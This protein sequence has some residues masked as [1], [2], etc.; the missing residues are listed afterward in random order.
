M[1]LNLGTTEAPEPKETGVYLREFLMDPLVLDIPSFW[2]WFLVNIIIV[3]RR[4]IASARAYKKIWLREGSPLLF[5]SQ[6][7]VGS[8]TQHLQGKFLVILGM[9]YGKPSIRQA[10][11]ELKNAG[12]E[13][14]Y[15]LPLYPQFADSSTRTALLK[16]RDELSSLNWSPQIAKCLPHFF[17]FS[18][19]SK[20]FAE[21][22]DDLN[23]EFCAD[24]IL[25]SYHG[26]PQRHLSQRRDLRNV[27]RF[28]GQC[29]GEWSSRNAL[30]YRAQCF[31]T[32]R[33]IVQLLD[34]DPNRS[35]TAFQSR[36][37]R[38]KWI[39]PSI[40][41]E[42]SRL[43]RA[44]VKRL[45]VSCPSFVTDC[46]ETLEE[47]GVR[48]KDL[49]MELG[50]EDLLLVPSLN[51]QEVWVKTLPE[52]LESNLWKDFPEILDDLKA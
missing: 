21:S 31:D 34:I 7:L 46:L 26:L 43:A 29:C 3:P 13:S 23:K 39:L 27:C 6:Q 52:V 25:F 48:M 22:I 14:M 15:I 37:G 42:L 24:H 30:C 49:F 28:D 40:E 35:S 20:A 51:S 41:D 38:A 10:L 17:W 36:L 16:V 11:E 32:T 33:R 4:K 5:Y 2:R 1:L 8:L 50:G 19:Y 9:R 12:V 45:L 44:G 47:V 18:G